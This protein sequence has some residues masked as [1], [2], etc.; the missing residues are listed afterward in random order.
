[1]T[2][3]QKDPLSGGIR[4]PG[5]KVFFTG[6]FVRSLKKKDQSPGSAGHS[7]LGSALG[8]PLP[9]SFEQGPGQV[10]LETQV[11]ED[12]IGPRFSPFFFFGGIFFCRPICNRGARGESR[13]VWSCRGS[14]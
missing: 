1:M 9:G 5:V 13:V 7:G 4:G 8:G 10:G 11:F 14:L 3:F 2:P 12:F 6:A